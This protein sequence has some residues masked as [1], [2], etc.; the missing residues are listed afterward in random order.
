MKSRKEDAKADFFE[1]DNDNDEEN[2]NNHNRRLGDAFED[3]KGRTK[4][5]LPGNPRSK[6]NNNNEENDN[7]SRSAIGAAL[8]K[9]T[10]ADDINRRLGRYPLKIRIF[11]RLY[12]ELEEV[13][14]IRR[15]R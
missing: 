13:G 11:S 2:N 7:D 12:P 15:R 5:R 4:G 1:K 6:D 3:A 8:L 10:S 9:L 14:D